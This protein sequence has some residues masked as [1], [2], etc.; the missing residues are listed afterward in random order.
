MP[1]H[2]EPPEINRPGAA[3]AAGD[4]ETAAGAAGPVSFRR[5]GYFAWSLNDLVSLLV[6]WWVSSAPDGVQVAVNG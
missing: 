1:C 3:G 4:G 5:C 6:R 2:A